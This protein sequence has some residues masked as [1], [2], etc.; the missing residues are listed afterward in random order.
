[1]RPARGFFVFSFGLFSI[2][3]QTLLFREFV[4]TFEGNDIA[5]GVFF[6]SWF[7]WVAVGATIVY[8]GR[9]AERL[10]PYVELMLLGY[11]G[12]YILQYVLI[13][14]GRQIAGLQSYTLFPTF[15]MTSL[16]LLV[17]APVSCMT[18]MLFPLICRWTEKGGQLPVS[19]V[20]LL[21]A[22]GSFCGGL[23]VTFL[24]YSGT[25]SETVFFLICLVVSLAVLSVKLMQRAFSSAVAAGL[26]VLAIAICLVAGV[27]KAMSGGINRLK[28]ARLLPA[29]SYSGSF[30]TSQAEY[31][32]GNYQGQWLVVRQGSVCESLPDAESTGRVA[33][34]SLCQAPH[35]RRVLVVGSGLG[36]CRQFLKL[37]QVELVA[38]AHYDAE[39]VQKVEGFAPA[40]FKIADDRFDRSTT[41]V[42]SLLAG[43]KDF[44][45]IVIVNQPGATSSVMNRYY[46]VGF[47]EQVR[48]SLTAGGVLAVGIAGG[49]NVIGTELV[50]VG[51]S[52]GRTLEKVFSNLVIT[53]GEETWFM[54][55][56]SDDLTG[57]PGILR[58]RFA[59]I[60]GAS[61]IFPP[62]GLFSVY[63]PDRAEKA[64]KAYAATDLPESMLINRDDRPLASFY[65]LL[66]SARQSGAPATR[67]LKYLAAAGIWPFIVPLA[68][69][70]VCRLVYVRRSQRNG[71][72]STFNSTFLVYSAGCAGMAAAIIMMFLY[73]GR[74]GSLYLHVGVFSSLFMLGIFAGSGLTRSVL[75]R[76][77]VR[78]DVFLLLVV[79]T[80]ALILGFG[81]T[82]PVQNWTHTAFA[83][84][85]ILLGICTG[86]YFPIAAAKLSDSGVQTRQAGSRL[87]MADHI[88]AATGAF[89]TGLV[90]VPLVGTAAALFIL[91]LL[92]LVN[93]VLSALRV[94]IKECPPAIST[95]VYLSRKLGYILFG[96]GVCVI[97]WSNLI[98]HAAG[99]MTPALPEQTVNALAEGL[100]LEK[101]SAMS[102]TVGYF[103]LKDA[104][105]ASAGYIFSTAQLAPQ[106][107]GFGGRFNL[108]VKV[109]Q[110]GHLLDYHIVRSNE[111]PSYLKLLTPWQDSHKGKNL[112]EPDPFADVQAVTGA[113]VS[114]QAFLSALETSGRRFASEILNLGS[115]AT[116]GKSQSALLPDIGAAYLMIAFVVA[117]LVSFYGGF[118]T[119]LLVLAANMVIGGILLN[120]QFSTAQISSLLSGQFPSVAASGV[121]LLAIGVPVLMMV[122]GNYYCGY[123]CPFGAL[124][125]LLGYIIPR[126]FMPA[127]SRDSMHWP[128]FTKYVVLFI[129]VT[130]FFV[131]R[132]YRTLSPD[133]LIEV[134]SAN[135]TELLIWIAAT[136]LVG[137]VLF[138]RF[139]C[140]YL[141]PAG[142]FLS[143]LGGV[144][145]L[146]RLMP[147]K[148]FG[149][150]EFAVGGKS[151]DCICC[152]RCRD[153]FG[154]K[155]RSQ[156]IPVLKSG[157]AG[158]L[159]RNLL[160]PVA[161]I[162]VC[163]SAIC[164][165]TVMET[166][167]PD[168]EITFSAAGAGQP[169]DADMDKI[170]AM[171]RENKLSDRKA[172]FYKEIE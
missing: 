158:L 16:S 118:R 91:I 85:L 30:H 130:A 1:M 109:N 74:F 67:F 120:A 14:Q 56:D 165:S 43:K 54:A 48:R 88:G 6:G 127:P 147:A 129:I 125:E 138:V 107:R 46:T 7:L 155:P 116:R 57:Q 112:F 65:S 144:A 66:L 15:L 61:E 37:D 3:A 40:E 47:Y 31:L 45:D 2:A 50:N 106:V 23:G 35:A 132:D 49:E 149:R 166:V 121:F 38:W 170:H 122:F 25:A 17:N 108:A 98:T 136:A 128:R 96:S 114:S 73:Q 22:A 11:I 133:P 169:R 62:Q 172:D 99:R 9:L 102:D 135:R 94:F 44:Y 103:N 79:I 72:A 78:A 87:E 111:T 39:Y 32:Y 134:F 163:V 160:I 26:L 76:S 75:L 100:V 153:G 115:P 124:Q 5:V 19:R 168:A 154:S 24:L 36:L 12:A 69:F 10:Q 28:W 131:C 42:R 140:R 63:L 142:A 159:S 86:S 18:G 60:E 81:C 113:T 77:R 58:D 52:A 156:T 143:L 141:C 119:R 101:T 8:A 152:D 145:V 97:L 29:E 70:L 150:C 90:V 92:M 27:D 137:S 95:P 41:D 110:S 83:L 151:L 64:I 21:E 93:V 167:G 161:V 59:G 68:V 126:R 157:P 34:I 164:L 171:I 80:H 105:G 20:Y 104:Q 13:M 117:L 123:I 139:W 4:T 82:W 84:V 33:A 71:R 55:S 146:K 162:A 148:K 89:F 51:A 53:P